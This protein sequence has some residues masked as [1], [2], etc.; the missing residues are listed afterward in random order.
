[1]GEEFSPPSPSN[2]LKKYQHKRIDL[3]RPVGEEIIVEVH[4]GVGAGAIVETT[5]QRYSKPGGDA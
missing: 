1:V 2:F 4:V 5:S 3:Y